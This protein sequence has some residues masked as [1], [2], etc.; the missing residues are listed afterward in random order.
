MLLPYFMPGFGNASH[1]AQN[2][3]ATNRFFEERSN[4][5]VPSSGELYNFSSHMSF[6]FGQTASLAGSRQQN[7]IDSMLFSLRTEIDREMSETQTTKCLID[8]SPFF[9][10]A[11][12]LAWHAVD[13][14]IVPVRTD[15]Q[16]IN[17]LNLLLRTLSDPAGAF[18]RIM[19]SDNHAPKIQLVVLTHCGW[20]TRAGARNQPNQQTRMYLEQVRDIVAR[21][22]T[23]FTTAIPDDHI[24]ILDDFL[25]SGR[26]ST[27]QSKPIELLSPGE[28]VT[29]Q[30]VRVE[31]NSSVEKIKAQLRFI[32][33]TIW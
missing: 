24:V 20:S 32:N 5:Y 28:T 22:I 33:D 14:L 31:V 7:I 16:S 12:H 27:A 6:A 8:T 25:G 15:Q 26:I 13:S 30:R 2:I 3:G 21:N 4:Y 1:V 11:T 17:S 29:I 23:H 19:P 10:G 18:R 9:A